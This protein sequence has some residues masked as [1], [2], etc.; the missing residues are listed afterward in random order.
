MATYNKISVPVLW[1]AAGAFLN[2]SLMGVSVQAQIIG[3]SPQPSSITVPGSTTPITYVDTLAVKDEDLG[4][5][6]LD[7]TLEEWITQSAIPCCAEEGGIAIGDPVDGASGGGLLYADEDGNLAQ[8]S[9]TPDTLITNSTPAGGDLEG[10]YP[11]PTVK[12]SVLGG[13]TIGSDVTG[14]AANSILLEDGTNKVAEVAGLTYSA[15]TFN[16]PGSI[17]ATANVTGAGGDLVLTARVPLT[18]TQILALNTTPVTLV[19]TPGSGKYIVPI[20]IV[21]D[22]TFVSASYNSATYQFKLGSTVHKAIRALL[23]A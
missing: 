6:Y 18:S 14:G 23:G 3:V 20:S 10:T 1:N 22:Y 4:V 12:A 5:L 16:V 9:E 21:V 8:A 11:N 15:F 13:I 2:G 7:M 17:N 19:A